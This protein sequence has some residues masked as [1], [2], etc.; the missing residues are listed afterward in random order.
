[1][2]RWLM[3]RDLSAKRE[4][5]GIEG[6][7]SRFISSP[8]AFGL[9]SVCAE[10]RDPPVTLPPRGNPRGAPARVAQNWVEQTR[11]KFRAQGGGLSLVPAVARDHGDGPASGEGNK[12]RARQRQEGGAC[13]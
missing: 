5:L 8:A 7:R 12:G 1:M 3:A 13:L 6:A 11:A 9:I 2:D 10:Q 4:E